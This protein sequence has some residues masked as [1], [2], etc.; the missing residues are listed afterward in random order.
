MAGAA[1]LAARRANALTT[2]GAV[3][4]AIIGFVVFGWGRMAAAWPLLVFFATASALTRVSARLRRRVDHAKAGFSNASFSDAKGRRAPQV[5]AN[6]GVAA[7]VVAA[8]WIWPHPLWTA[9]FAGAIATSTADTWA[10]ELG[11]MSRRAPVLI[12]TW[13]PAQPGQSGAVSLAG[14]LAGG[15]GAALIAAVAAVTFGRDALGAS[16]TVN[17]PFLTLA[18]LAG[19]TIGMLLD[20]VLGATV[21]ARYR[22]PACHAVTEERYHMCSGDESLRHPR[23]SGGLKPTAAARSRHGSGG[24]RDKGLG[25]PRVRTVLVAGRP[26][27]DNDVVNFVASLGGAVAAAFIYWLNGQ[28]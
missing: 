9:A 17:P 1:A 10:T 6:G 12:T 16:V 8:S 27:F 14:T 22:C 24:A 28:L 19:G 3:A 26:V 20:S 2:D 5:L 13:K 4:A 21:Q 18:A 25:A 7:A 11:V 23:A 15:A